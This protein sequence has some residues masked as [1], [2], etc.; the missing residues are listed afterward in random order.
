MSAPTATP[1]RRRLLSMRDTM[2]RL[3]C[4]RTTVYT[5]IETD[6]TFPRP[7][8][9]GSRTTFA[10][11]LIDAWIDAQIRRAQGAAAEPASTDRPAARA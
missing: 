1:A 2:D 6:P 9:V 7:V 8:K 4:S 3:G 11:H 5:L 10:D